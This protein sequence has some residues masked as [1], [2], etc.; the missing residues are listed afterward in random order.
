MNIQTAIVNL[1]DSSLGEY[2]AM[3]GKGSGNWGHKGRPGKRGGSA[4]TKGSVPAVISALKSTATNL[5]DV[6]NF[7]LKDI[8]G[9]RSANLWITPKGEV[10]QVLWHG[11][12]GITTPPGTFAKMVRT[13]WGRA[14]YGDGQ[15]FIDTVNKKHAILV[16]SRIAQQRRVTT[17]AWSPGWTDDIPPGGQRIG[18]TLGDVL[19]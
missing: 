4:P 6:E 17:F 14:G 7:K 10:Y 8:V 9:D 3:G 5:G 16:L 2:V 11:D 1:I 13:G 12:I 15:A 19:A 18:P